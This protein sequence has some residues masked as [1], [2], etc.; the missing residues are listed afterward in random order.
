MIRSIRSLFAVG[1]ALLL[2]SSIMVACG[3]GD[4]CA[5][6]ADC[7]SKGDDYKCKLNTETNKRTCQQE[8]ASTVCK[9]TDC[10]SDDDCKDCSDGKT[11]CDTAAKTC[12]TGGSSTVCKE[13]DCASDDDCKDCSG[14]K[15]KCDTAT[16]TCGTGGSSTV[17]KNPCS[18]NS[19][20]K[21][22]SGG[23]NTCNNGTCGPG[24]NNPAVGDN[25]NPQQADSCGTDG[26]LVCLAVSQ[27]EA[28]CGEVC[29]DDAGCTDPA[30]NKCVTLS[31]GTTKVCLGEADK[32][33]ACGI[34]GKTQVVCKEGTTPPLGCQGGKCVELQVVATNE[35]CGGGSTKTCADT[36]I[37]VTLA[38]GASN[39]YCL[40]K[41]D[42]ANNTCPN[43]GRCVSLQGSGG[44]CIPAGTAAEGADCEDVSAG[45]A[46]LDPAKMCASGFSCDATTKKCVKVPEAATFEACGGNTG[47]QCASTDICV[48]FSQTATQGF[49]LTTCDPNAPNCANGG[50]CLALSG[51]SGACGLVGT[52][53]EDKVCES[54]GDTAPK[55]DPATSCAKGLICLVFSDGVGMCTSTL[56]GGCS[57]GT[58][59]GTNRKCID[60]QSGDGACAKDC[61]TTDTCTTDDPATE[62][63][64]LT[65]QVGGKVCAPKPVFGP[66]DF[67]QI[68]S[69]PTKTNGCKEGLLCMRQASTDP[70][71]F[72]SK[73]CT[74]DTDCAGYKNSAGTAING[75]CVQNGQNKICL[76]DCSQ[77]GSTCPDGTTCQAL[78]S[79]AQFCFPG[80]TP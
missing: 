22:C 43:N 26:K 15:T 68:C 52:L 72:C 59:P 16:K 1:L 6:D 67:G 25:C 56:A 2:A 9:E 45:G 53:T 23:N 60:L 51:G 79:G 69:D 74:T 42:P 7:A 31:D 70:S 4:E 55:L 64:D 44:A 24:G 78:S 8:T 76:F 77:P 39:G 14:G 73:T 62:C 30:R 27:T 61:T 50:E 71:G 75:T 18:T 57:S 40:T 48:R 49:C 37:C 54:A 13:T 19:D 66:N 11:K 33:G 41:C 3:G 35:A 28:Y 38:S 10:A 5:K 21:D 47:K 80:S 12:G 17:C 20:C 63:L 32:D 46:K 29:T 65:S 58:C 34:S 36:D